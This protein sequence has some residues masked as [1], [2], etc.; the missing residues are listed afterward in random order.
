MTKIAEN[1]LRPGGIFVCS[2]YGTKAEM[3]QMESEL[4]NSSLVR[5]VFNQLY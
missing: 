3:A 1:L 5:N 2:D 4:A